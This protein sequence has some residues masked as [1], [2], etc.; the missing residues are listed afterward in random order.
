ML[1]VCLLYIVFY[2]L[3]LLLSFL[4]DLNFECKKDLIFILI[5]LSH[6]RCSTNGLIIILVQ[7][8]ALHCLFRSTNLAEKVQAYLSGVTSKTKTIPR[9]ECRQTGDL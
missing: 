1:C 8:L 6:C 4:S 2:L 9:T 7:G 3:L 5:I